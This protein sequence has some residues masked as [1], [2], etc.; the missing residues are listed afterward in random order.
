MDELREYGWMNWREYGWMNW[1]E[2]G[3]MNWREYGWMNW[4][5]DVIVPVY[6]SL[7]YWLVVNLIINPLH[8]YL[9]EVYLINCLVRCIPRN[10]TCSV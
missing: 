2:Y 7:H 9:C 5:E 6:G 10:E 8:T 4:R 3:W 1:R